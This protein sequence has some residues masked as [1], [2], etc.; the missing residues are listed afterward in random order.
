MTIPDRK[1]EIRK[2]VEQEENERCPNDLTRAWYNGAKHDRSELLS[3]LDAVE[4]ERD[5]L[6]Q[7]Y[8]ALVD[9]AI[10][11]RAA[12]GEPRDGSIHDEL[13]ALV[14]A[15]KPLLPI[16]EHYFVDPRVDLT[17]EEFVIEQKKFDEAARISTPI[18]LAAFDAV[19][20]ST[21]AQV[22]ATKEV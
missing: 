2:R 5:Q 16:Q 12:R 13:E 11:L 10:A 7:K 14:R 18:D 6:K 22:P 3:M 1:A 21:P 4:S 20:L 19:A 8:A 15:L 9:A 17:P